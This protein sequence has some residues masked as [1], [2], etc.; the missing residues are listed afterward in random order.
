VQG[1]L[2][3]VADKDLRKV[4]IQV[5]AVEGDIRNHELTLTRLRDDP[6]IVAPTP[7]QN[8][9]LAIRFAEISVSVTLVS[10]EDVSRRVER[11]IHTALEQIRDDRAKLEKAW[12]SWSVSNTT[13]CPRTRNAFSNS[14]RVRA[15]R[16]SR[17]FLNS[18]AWRGTPFSTDSRTLLCHRPFWVKEDAQHSALELP[19]LNEAECAL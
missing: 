3:E 15:T 8:A 2:V 12:P 13:I 4:R 9:G 14:C 19:N 17:R 7:H 10:L 18:C 6:T 16:I 1:D 11:G 5:E